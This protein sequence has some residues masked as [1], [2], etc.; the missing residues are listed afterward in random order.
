MEQITITYRVAE[1]QPVQTVTVK[2]EQM[3]K[4]ISEFNDKGYI[5]ESINSGWQS[6]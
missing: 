1:G 3:K 4:K 2:M 6:L 5:I